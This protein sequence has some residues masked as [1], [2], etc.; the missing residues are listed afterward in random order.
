MLLA[1]FAPAGSA[2]ADAPFRLPA[3]AEWVDSG[4]DVVAGQS[5]TITAYGY[6]LTGPLKDF[7]DAH[8]GPDGQITACWEVVAGHPC[9][10]DSVP[11]GALVG[12]IGASGVPFL[13]GSSNSFTPSTSGDLY[14]AVNDNLFDYGDNAGNFIVF[15]MP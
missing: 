1:A 4:F 3:D 5:V 6:A 2:R 13:I 15:F 7:P 14:L 11:Y 9:A 8:S 10:L 12:K